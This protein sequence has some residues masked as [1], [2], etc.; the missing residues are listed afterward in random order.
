MILIAGSI[1]MRS[2][3]PSVMPGTVTL[4][5][6]RKSSKYRAILWLLSGQHDHKSA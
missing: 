3:L 1:A 2:M 6:P 5:W 4:R